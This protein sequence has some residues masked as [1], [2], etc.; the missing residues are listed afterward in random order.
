MVATA[1]YCVTMVL[2]KETVFPLCRAIEKRWNGNAVSRVSSVIVVIRL[3][4]CQLLLLLL[5]AYYYAACNAPCVGHKDGES[6]ALTRY[7]PVGGRR[8]NM[9]PRKFSRYKDLRQSMDPK[10]SADLH[11]SADGSTVRTSL[12]ASGG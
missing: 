10:I 8:D 1:I 4:I 12:V 3:P 9:R 5:V 11:S 6:Q 7:R 2:W